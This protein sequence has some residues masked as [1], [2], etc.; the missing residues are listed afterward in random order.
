M[1]LR[2]KITVLLPELK[3]YAT[4]LTKDA[5]SAADLSQEAIKKALSA[6]NVPKNISDLRPWMFRIIRNTHIDQIRKEKTRKEYSADLARLSNEQYIQTPK[7]IEEILIRQALIEITEKERE[8]LYLIDVMGL[9]YAEAAIVLDIAS[10]T[11]MSRVS[12]ARRSLLDK[13][14]RTNI[15]PIDRKRKSNDYK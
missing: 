8:I 10:G 7:V 9:K 3:A 12:R 5:D 6:S 11:V 13:V 1:F 2:R 4:A 14:E 15:T